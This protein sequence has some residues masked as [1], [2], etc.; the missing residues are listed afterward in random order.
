MQIASYNINK[1]Q[2]ERELGLLQKKVKELEIREQFQ[3]TKQQ[4]LT[5]SF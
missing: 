3:Q 5:H 1:E 2:F 4:T